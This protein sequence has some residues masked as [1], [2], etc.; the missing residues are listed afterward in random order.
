MHR[1]MSGFDKVYNMA[2]APLHIRVLQSPIAASPRPGRARNS[3][4]TP[5]Y[6]GPVTSR[7]K[8]DLFEM[9]IIPLHLVLILLTKMEKGT[10][11]FGV[12]QQNC[13]MGYDI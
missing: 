11:W 8:V 4:P 3:L 6:L 5:F 1:I 12:Q 7:R 10:R 13:N 9:C 2:T